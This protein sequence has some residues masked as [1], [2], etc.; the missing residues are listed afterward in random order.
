[1]NSFCRSL[2]DPIQC[3]FNI[4]AKVFVSKKKKIVHL[5]LRKPL[6]YYSYFKKIISFIRKYWEDRKYFCP[7]PYVLR[8]IQD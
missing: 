4:D 3:E 1:M 7:Q 5:S 6:I 8:D 2:T